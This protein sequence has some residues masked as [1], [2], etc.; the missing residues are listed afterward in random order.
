MIELSDGHSTRVTVIAYKPLVSSFIHVCN[1]N[2]IEDITYQSW[3]RKYNRRH[4][5]N[6]N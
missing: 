3:V 2:E 6:N 1:K 4:W 5:D